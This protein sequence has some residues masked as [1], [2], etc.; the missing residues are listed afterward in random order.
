MS[1]RSLLVSSFALVGL[2]ALAGCSKSSA[3]ASAS[4]P[5]TSEASESSG[6]KSEKSEKAKAAKVIKIE[7]LGLKAEAPGETEDPII[8]DGDPIM[9]MAAFF[10]VN[11]AAA[12]PTD[13]KKLKDG[14]D[15]AGLFNPKNMKSETLSDGWALT[16]ENTGSAGKNYFVSVR[17][18][19]GGKGYLCDTTQSTPEQQKTALAFCKALTAAK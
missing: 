1:V 10:T 16:F 2:I 13:P 14:E 17:R 9:I 15:A 4:T 11:V 18:E 12:K 8:G 6:K 5:S 3:D 7:K 19:I